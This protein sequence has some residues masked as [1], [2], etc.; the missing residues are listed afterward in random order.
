[1]NLIIKII[2]LRSSR[3]DLRRAYMEV[4]KRSY[5][6]FYMIFTS[7]RFSAVNSCE[8]SA[9]FLIAERTEKVRILQT[10]SDFNVLYIYAIVGTNGVILQARFGR[11]RS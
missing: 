10:D 9:E 7:L 11:T 6:L 1:M 8:N 4:V 2:P 5:E 3:R